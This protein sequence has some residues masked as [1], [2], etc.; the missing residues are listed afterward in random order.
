MR[1]NIQLKMGLIFLGLLLIICL[2]GP[3][4]PFI[5]KELT[6]TGAIMSEDEGKLLIPP[7]KPSS[8]FWFGSDRKGVDLLSR[9]VVGAKDMLI[10]ILSITILR[11]LIAIPL[12]LFAFYSKAVNGLLQFLNLALSFVPAIFMIILFINMPYLIFSQHRITWVIFIIAFLDVGRVAE[13][14]KQQVMIISQKPYI[15]A[16]ITLGTRP[17]QLMRNYYLP[18]LY[19][20]LLINV[21]L[22][23]GRTTFIIGQLGIIGIYVSHQV[24]AINAMNIPVYE[25]QNTSN[26]WPLLFETLMHDIFSAPWIPIF[27]GLAI[28]LVILGFFTLA[29]GVRRHFRK[30]VQYF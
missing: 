8:E 12:G 2:I 29:E 1:L 30:G 19:P 22:D 17:V 5:D 6:K 15:E 18:V 24:Q 16:A 26:A 10:L 3:H 11:Y 28:T 21:I 4:L 7:F 14:V 23:L 27:T 13:L 20:E 25:L 9:I